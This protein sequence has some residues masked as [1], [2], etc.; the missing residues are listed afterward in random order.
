VIKVV[1]FDFDGTLVDS[2]AIKDRCFD[3]VVAHLPGGQDALT[4]ARGAGGDRYQIFHAVARQL[5]HAD[6]VVGAAALARRLAADYTRR[7]LHSISA[8]PERRGA[9]A[10]LRTLRQRG[11]KVWV[12]SST[13]REDLLPLLRTRGT[14]PLINGVHGAPHS[15]LQNLH[16]ILAAERVK[17]RQV[18]V[19]GDG[20]DDEEAARRSGTWFVAVT[21]KRRQHTALAMPDLVHLPAVLFRLAGA[22]LRADD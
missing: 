6:G 9:H 20:K 16:A 19:V 3:E 7:C 12:N 14:L 22:R 4:R 2:N 5:N 21:A 17:A 18:V 8:A 11:L 10:A 13:P 1:V 15:K